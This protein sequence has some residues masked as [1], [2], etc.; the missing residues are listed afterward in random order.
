MHVAARAQRLG[1]WGNVGIAQL[2][3]APFFSR[4]LNHI[5][6]AHAVFVV[7]HHAIIKSHVFRSHIQHFCRHLRQMLAQFDGAVLGRV[8]GHIRL[9]RCGCGPAV[10]RQV[11]VAQ[12]NA[13]LVKRQTQL[14]RCNRGHHA[15]QTLANFCRAAPHFH[16]AVI[17]S[18]NLNFALVGCAAAKASVFVGAGKTP[19][20][21]L[22][23]LAPDHGRVLRL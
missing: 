17:V 1:F 7:L 21:G 6:K 23:A 2:G 9:A 16:R 11:G 19:G 20:V 14:L 10:W 8:S 22:V 3:D 18:L 4:L 12:Q 15:R 5:A 13:H